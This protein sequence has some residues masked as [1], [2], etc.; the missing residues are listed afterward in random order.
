MQTDISDSFNFLQQNLDNLASSVVPLWHPLGFVSC[1]IDESPMQYVARVHYWPAGERRVKN[2]D[3]P[4]HTHSYALKSLV[5]SGQLQDLQ[6]RAEPGDQWSIYSV[7]YFEGG[8]EIVRTSENVNALPSID[9]F[10]EA[11][12]Q[13]E[14]PLGV[15]HQTKVPQDQA[16]VTLVLLTDIGTES[17]KVLGTK[18]AEKYPYDRIEFNPEVF[19]KAVREAVEFHLANHSR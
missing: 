2:P 17:P 6:Y 13:Y 1:V 19:W 12:A 16:A 18:Q 9:E 11:G 10:R 7:N 4:I 15:F 14:V 3:W 5:L 8:S